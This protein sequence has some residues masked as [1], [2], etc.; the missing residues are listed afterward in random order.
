MDIAL[1]YWNVPMA[2]DSVGKTAFLCT[3]GLYEWLVLSFVLYYAVPAFERLVEN[4]LVDLKWRI[5]LVYLDDCIVFSEDC[6][7]HL[8]RLKQVLQRFRAL[9]SSSR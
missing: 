8:V 7:T 1:G 5:Y 9:V 6:S 3:Y 2:E 4:V